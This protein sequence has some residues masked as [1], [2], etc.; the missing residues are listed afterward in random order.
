MALNKVYPHSID[1]EMAVLGAMLISKESIDVVS[2]ILKSDYF[3]LD[4]HKRIFDSILKLVESHNSVDLI[5]VSDEL[6]KQGKLEEIGGQAY[7]SELIEK[8]STPAHTQNYARIVKEK[9]I[10]RELIN[11][12]SKMIEKAYEDSEDLD[13]ILDKAQKDLFDISQ[14]NTDHGFY[15]PEILSKEFLERMDILS[16]QKSSII[17]VPTGFRELDDATGGFQKS[18]FIILAA[19]PSQGKTAM[20]LNMAY[21]IGIEKQIPV[22]FFSLEMDRVS[23]MNR[24]IGASLGINVFDVR[25]GRFPREKWADITSKIEEFSRANIWIDDSPSLNIMEIRARTRKLMLELKSKNKDFDKMIVFID[26]LQLVKGVGKHENRQQE[27]SEISRLLK[28]MAR[29]M[30]IPVVAL[31]QLN[32]RSEEKGRDGNK[33][34]LSDLRESGSLEQDADVVALIHRDYYYTKN[35]EDENKATLIIAKNRN[36]PVKPIDLFF[37]PEWTKFADPPLPGTENLHEEEVPL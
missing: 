9:F 18:E 33:P 27:V 10:L 15:S 29:S 28:D 4:S 23:L 34:Q 13:F 35:K 21:H 14:K 32:R 22:A 16:R 31:A 36:G 20:A 37:F 11:S 24:M 1:A 2:E 17:G 30:G 5:T 19:R 8:V 12:C 7:L 6:K 3:Y 25:R 26:Y